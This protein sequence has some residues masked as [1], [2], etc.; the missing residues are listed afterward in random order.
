MGDT[1]IAIIGAHPT[2]SGLTTMLPHPLIS[3]DTMVPIT[4]NHLKFTK[5]WPIH[6]KNKDN[7]SRLG[8]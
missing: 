5:T 4:I 3:K 1:I 7:K 8:I 6:S 2:I